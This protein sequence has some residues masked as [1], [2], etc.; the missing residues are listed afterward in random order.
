M[1]GVKFDSSGLVC[2]E[3]FRDVIDTP[4]VVNASG[5]WVNKVAAFSGHQFPAEAIREQ[6]TV[7]YAV[8]RDGE[9]VEFVVYDGPT[10]LYYRPEGRDLLLIGRDNIE[11]EYVDPDDFNKKGDMDFV[12]DVLE[13]MQ[14]RWPYFENAKLFRGWGC[15]YCITP[16]WMPILDRYPEVPGYYICTGMSGHGFKLAPAVGEMMAELIMTGSCEEPDISDY[17]LARFDEGDLMQSVFG[18]GFQG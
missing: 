12:L 18:T 15:L 17:R 1:I 7:F 13:R 5:A 16:D 9:R 6:D 14:K 8:G 11:P 4:V 10:R 3:T 2:V